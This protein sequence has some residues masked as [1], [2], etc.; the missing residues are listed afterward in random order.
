M[1][2]FIFGSCFETDE[3]RC[4]HGSHGKEP[5][6][7]HVTMQHAPLRDR[8]LD[9]LDV[10]PELHLSASAISTSPTCKVI[11]WIQCQTKGPRAPFITSN[12]KP[13]RLAATS[14]C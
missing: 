5:L 8:D 13:A 10:E 7:H 4:R 3:A 6:I 11:L 12:A 9:R 1:T 14:W 2:S